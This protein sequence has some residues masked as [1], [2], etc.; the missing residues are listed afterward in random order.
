MGDEIVHKLRFLFADT[1]ILAA[2]D[3][4]DRDSGELPSRSLPLFIS[5]FHGFNFGRMVDHGLHYSRSL[6]RVVSRQLIRHM[7]SESPQRPD[8]SILVIKYTSSW[9]RSYYEVLGSTATY[10]VF[11]K[12]LFDWAT[13]TMSAYCTCPAFTYAVLMSE[14]HTMVRLW[15]TSGKFTILNF[16][17]VQAHLSDSSSGTDVSM[18]DTSH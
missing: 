5:I 16:Y 14:S 12:L 18:S 11:P 6:C 17:A 8:C 1:L 4:V 15:H 9:G 7:S 2:L 3:L 10:T 13:P